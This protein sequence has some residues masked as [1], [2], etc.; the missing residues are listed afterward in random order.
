LI[1]VWESGFSSSTRASRT[2]FQSGTSDTVEKPPK[3]ASLKGGDIGDL[4]L[5]GELGE[6]VLASLEYNGPRG[7]PNFDDL[8]TLVDGS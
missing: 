3:D 1:N 4:G 2:L 6:Q 8:K 5:H 7:V